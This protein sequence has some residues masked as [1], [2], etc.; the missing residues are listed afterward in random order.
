MGTAWALT[1]VN[2]LQLLTSIGEMG[3]QSIDGNGC[4][5]GGDGDAASLACPVST[6]AI[7]SGRTTIDGDAMV[8][9]SSMSESMPC[10]KSM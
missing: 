6:V 10:A 2:S 3:T 8:V 5:G 1:A 7:V 9:T 4:S